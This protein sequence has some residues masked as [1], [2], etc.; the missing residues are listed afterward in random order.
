MLEHPHATRA[1]MLELEN[2]GDVLDRDILE[3]FAQAVD[4][5]APDIV[6]A[7][8]LDPFRG[9]AAAKVEIQDGADLV[10]LRESIGGVEIRRQIG[11]AAEDLADHLH[12]RHGDR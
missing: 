7:K 4:R 3:G 8:E 2:R 11:G 10:T 1:W 12:R 6:L 9:R 5:R